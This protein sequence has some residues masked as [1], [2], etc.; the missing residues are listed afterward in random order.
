MALQNQILTQG[1]SFT[2]PGGNTGIVNFNT[3]TGQQLLPGQTTN[4]I[5]SGP[6]PGNPAIVT[7]GPQWD[8]HNNATAGLN[9]FTN[10]P[11]PYMQLFQQ[12]QQANALTAGNAIASAS[13]ATQRSQIKNEA[14]QNAVLAGMQ[15]AAEKTGLSPNSAYEMQAI[16]GAKD[17]FNTRFTLL[18]Q[19]EKLAVA[20]AKS[21]QA[22]GDT[23]VLK[24]QLAYAQQL[25]TEKAKAQQDALTMDWEKY[26]FENLSADQKAALKI[27]Q[28]NADRLSAGG[29][30]EKPLSTAWLNYYKKNYPGLDVGP[31]DTMGGAQTAL[32]MNKTLTS[33]V[34]TAFNN[35]QFVR[36]GYFT[37]DYINQLVKALP[38]GVSKVGFL[39]SIA[40][41]LAIGNDTKA[42]AYGITPAERKTILGL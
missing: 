2:D 41:K 3:Q 32:D 36:N 8:A 26:K 16:Q 34:N 20:K 35:P 29:G 27:Q 40:D 15:T 39:T 6:V 13:A 4:S 12:Q 10:T 1:Q 30:A 7:T 23:A 17:S 28:Q 18:D 42:K 9:S 22:V 19:Q 25:R 31:G 5:P 38:P 21:A 14:D 37:Y 33:A 24:E 11:D